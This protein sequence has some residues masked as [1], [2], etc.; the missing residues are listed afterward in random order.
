MK[1]QSKFAH[2]S[3]ALAT[4]IALA[5][6]SQ[7]AMAATQSMGGEVTIQPR[8][9]STE[10]TDLLSFGDVKVGPTGGTVTLSND[11]TAVASVTGDVLVV[12]G[13]TEGKLGIQGEQNYTV[14]V[15][16]DSNIT[17]TAT[18]VSGAADLTVTT[19][20]QGSTMTLLAD[21]GS[22]NYFHIGGT[23]TIPGNQPADVYQ[24]NY[25]ATVNYQ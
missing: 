3:L 7:L 5:V 12:N 14:T 17:L 15:T 22:W 23:L 16:V 2:R 4:G 13:G 6:G 20:G 1:I 10:F 25:N 21:N 19:A 11:G 24:G 9:I 18:N 8:D